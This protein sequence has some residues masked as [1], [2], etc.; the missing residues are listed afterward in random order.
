M[1][2]RNSPKAKSN[3]LA[4]IALW[5]AECIIHRDYRSLRIR[6]ACYGGLVSTLSKWQKLQPKALSYG[7]NST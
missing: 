2:F 7:S 4:I 6:L 1:S 5:C 3:A